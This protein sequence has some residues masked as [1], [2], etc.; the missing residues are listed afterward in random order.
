[1]QVTFMQGPQGDI[2]PQGVIGPQGPVGRVGPQGERGPR[3]DG[4]APGG[5]SH[6]PPPLSPDATT[7]TLPLQ[8]PVLLDVRA[9]D[10]VLVPSL[11]TRLTPH[12]APGAPGAPAIPPMPAGTGV[13]NG[14]VHPHPY[15][16]YRFCAL[17][18]S[19][20][21]GALRSHSAAYQRRPSIA[22]LGR[23]SQKHDNLRRPRLLSLQRFAC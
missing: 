17:I 18:H 7:F 13:I 21:T 14:M 9:Y 19:A 3:G 2:G 16:Q 4:G 11:I 10:C 6:P 5:E 15:H 20:T 8:F 23:H 1:V 12:A 22:H